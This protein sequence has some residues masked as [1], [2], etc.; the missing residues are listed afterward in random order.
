[1]ITTIVYVSVKPEHLDAFIEASV[2]NHEQSVKEPGNMRFDF[3]QRED[4]P[5]QFV[6]YE[7]YEDASS[8]AAHKETAHYKKW[9]ETVAEWMA[10]PRKGVR[11]QGIKPSSSKPYF[12]NL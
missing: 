1:M 11:Y 7:A 3:L 9:R 8:A 5:T 2:E 6:L 10:V 4:T 12:Y